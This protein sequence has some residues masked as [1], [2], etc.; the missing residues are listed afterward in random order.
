MTVPEK[1]RLMETLWADLSRYVA[2]LE[3]PAWHAQAL[4]ETEQRLAE[5][6]EVAIDWET[7]KNQLRQRLPCEL[8]S[9]LRPPGS[10]RN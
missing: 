5:G 2:D 7:V 1:L 8:K 4:Q 3:L 10:T 6:K 9:S